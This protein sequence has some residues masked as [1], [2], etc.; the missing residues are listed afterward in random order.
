MAGKSEGRAACQKGLWII[1]IEDIGFCQ[2]F[3]DGDNI[4]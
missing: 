3:D 1:L 2:C 4:N